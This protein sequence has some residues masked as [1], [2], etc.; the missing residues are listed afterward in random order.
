MG[1]T[2]NNAMKATFNLVYRLMQLPLKPQL[3]LLQQCKLKPRG[4]AATVLSE[5]LKMK[6]TRGSPALQMGCQMVQLL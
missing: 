2:V 4:D 1:E 3:A 5:W 6:V